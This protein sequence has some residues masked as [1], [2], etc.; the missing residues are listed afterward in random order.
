[1][2]EIEKEI[3]TLEREKDLNP[4]FETYFELAQSYEEYSSLGLLEKAVEVYFRNQ[5]LKAIREALRIKPADFEARLF[6]GQLLVER[7]EMKDAKRILEKLT[8]EKTNDH[9]LYISLAEA[10]FKEKNYHQVKACL[11]KIKSAEGLPLN[12]KEMIEVWT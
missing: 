12:F 4:S 8:K 7:G 2:E 10:Y 3:S 1:M 11:H 9:R 5:S 6:L